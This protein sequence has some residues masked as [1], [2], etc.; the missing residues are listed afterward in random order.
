VQQFSSAATREQVKSLLMAIRIP[1]ERREGANCT[2]VLMHKLELEFQRGLCMPKR[3]QMPRLQA[4]K[5]RKPTPYC[6]FEV[7]WFAYV[8]GTNASAPNILRAQPHKCAR[9]SARRSGHSHSA[10]VVSV[11]RDVNVCT[12]ATN[13][14]D[15]KAN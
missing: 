3:P 8:R 13:Y 12:K 5:C 10:Y 9:R 4:Q 7:W 6:V 14:S 15:Q 2:G 1:T 11:L